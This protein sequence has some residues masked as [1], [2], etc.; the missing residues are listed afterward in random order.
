[1]SEDMAVPSWTPWVT[2]LLLIIAGQL[3]RWAI[4][5]LV[6]LFRALGV[7]ASYK[8]TREITVIGAYGGAVLLV[9][10]VPNLPST[11]V[12]TIYAVAAVLCTTLAIYLCLVLLLAA[13]AKAAAA[14]W[15]TTE[16][17]AARPAFSG[18]G[19]PSAA[20]LAAKQKLHAFNE[21]RGAF[22]LQH[23]LV[24]HFRFAEYLRLS[25]GRRLERLVGVHRTGAALALPLVALLRAVHADACGAAEAGGWSTALAFGGCGL[26]LAA[27]AG[28]AL[29]IC[30]RARARLLA[31]ERYWTTPRDVNSP[32]GMAATFASISRGSDGGG[33]SRRSS[34]WRSTE[35]WLADGGGS[36]TLI[37]QHDGS[38]L[39]VPPPVD[40]TPA[41]TSGAR[42]PLARRGSEASNGRFSP[43]P[44]LA[45]ADEGGLGIGGGGL[46]G[47]GTRSEGA[48]TPAPYRTDLKCV[49]PCRW[50]ALER[51]CGWVRL[52]WRRLRSAPSVYVASSAALL[53]LLQALLFAAATLL[54]L[55]ALPLDPGCMGDAP[56]AT[57]ARAPAGAAAVAV[58]VAPA[59]LALALLVYIVP[60]Y[61]VVADVG[62][63]VNAE[64]L[65]RL[66]GGQS[67]DDALV[68]EEGRAGRAG[69]AR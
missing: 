4:R 25:L 40:A 8:L 57:M 20:L 59:L 36:S 47:T 53:R 66:K 3:V 1:M 33:R 7:D 2:W 32:R 29:A 46:G 22:V 61:G 43:P 10:H 55:A 11:I 24:Q 67:L 31:S 42:S 5:A 30:A 69:E 52:H 26:A 65:E 35:Q 68:V 51:C 17:A 16:R 23:G 64:V 34:H 9:S 45:E 15:A 13:R 27:A 19:T 18:R 12:Q 14:A 58:G 56:L 63:A 6:S 39:Y 37:R 41:G 38:L 60:H 28:G 49:C 21:L 48:S 62:L 54:A 50:G 44:T